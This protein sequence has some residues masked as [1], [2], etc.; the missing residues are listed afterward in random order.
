MA[1]KVYSGDDV[2][3]RMLHMMELQDIWSTCYGVLT[4]PGWHSAQEK[5][6]AKQI[7]TALNMLQ[8]FMQVDYKDSTYAKIINNL[9]KPDEIGDAQ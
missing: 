8:N 4:S 7:Q 3:S 5:E 1:E 6:Q 2:G 9:P